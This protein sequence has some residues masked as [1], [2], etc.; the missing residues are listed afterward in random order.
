MDPGLLTVRWK[1][2]QE[3]DSGIHGAE[4]RIALSSTRSSCAQQVNDEH[5]H[6]P[7]TPHE[8]RTHRSAACTC[9]RLVRSQFC[10]DL[11]GNARVSESSGGI[12]SGSCH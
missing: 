12:T 5:H 10:N 8:H 3:L 2:G 6:P 9:S 1:K 11:R 7:T 4:A